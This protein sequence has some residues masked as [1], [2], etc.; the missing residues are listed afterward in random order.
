M[1][2]NAVISSYLYMTFK[3][4]TFELSFVVS[5]QKSKHNVSWFL[6]TVHCW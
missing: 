1:M 4:N 5:I 3:I 2:E 6:I